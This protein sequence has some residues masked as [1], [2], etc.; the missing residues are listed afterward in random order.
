MKTPGQM[1]APPSEFIRKLQVAQGWVA[2]RD[3][4]RAAQLFK[5]LLGG[6]EQ[7]EVVLAGLGQCLCQLNRANEGIP[8]LRKAGQ[9]LFRQA[10]QTGRADELFALIHQLIHW[11]ALDDALDLAKTVLAIAPASAHA[12][13]LAALALQGLNRAPEAWVHASRAAALLPGD[14][15][16][17][18]L[19]AV[20]EAKTGN[21]A[22]ARQRLESIVARPHDA[23]AGRA[24]LELGI[25]LDKSGEF[26]KAYSHL[27]TAGAMTLDSPAARRI[28]KAVA[29]RDIAQLRAGIEPA[30]L[31]S[32]KQRVIADN[33]PRPVFLMGFYRSG[34]TLAEQV[35]AAHPN[36]IT[37]GET[38][39]LGYVLAELSK[40]LPGQ[41]GLAERIRALDSEQIGYLRNLYWTIAR[42][43]FGDEVISG[44]LVDKTTLNT[45][46]V[47][48][49]NALFPDAHLLFT[50]RDPRDICLSCI[51]QPFVLSPL[52]IHLLTLDSCAR[53]YAAV[54]DYWLSVRDVVAVSWTE[55]RY[56]QLVVDLEGQFKPVFQKLGLAWSDNCLQFYRHAQ[57]HVVKTPSFDQVTRPLY[58]S[59][60][61]R[62]RH[63][64]AHIDPVMPVLQ[65]IIHHYGY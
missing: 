46:N 27:S 11:H 55:L 54:M 53:F 59:S 47:E 50:V 6:R 2:Q 24:H 25:L 40:M 65:P 45:L 12:H 41:A 9:L 15:N 19:A 35:L 3:Y 32:A 63:Y 20:L 21:I 18:I 30:F 38:H 23:N 26:D 44:V 10:K 34:S 36:V 61:G 13:H 56:E 33:L 42:R 5:A 29:Y 52:T 8:Y 1:A 31:R 49:I 64:Q 43:E 37:S 48:L 28:D 62:W 51:S 60:V 57:R 58:S 7:A 14:S 4:E 22:D 16:A 39:L 17:Q